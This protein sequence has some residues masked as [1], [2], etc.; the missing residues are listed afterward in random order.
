MITVIIW[1][2]FWKLGNNTEISIL[3]VEK[4]VEEMNSTFDRDLKSKQE[5]LSETQSMLR[6]LTKELAEVRR[7]NLALR[8]QAAQ[9]PDL[10]QKTKMLETALSEETARLQLIQSGLSGATTDS[11]NKGTETANI[12]EAKPTDSTDLQKEV[13]DLRS[14]VHTHEVE[15][16]KLRE[17]L[18][19]IRTKTST[20][21]ALYRKI[22]ALCTNTP[23][24]QIDDEYV[25]NVLTAAETDSEIDTT[26][27]ASFMTKMRHHENNKSG[28]VGSGGNNGSVSG[29]SSLRS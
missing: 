17:A 28:S 3:A 9:L 24:N 6:E 19:A 7:Q 26:A 25:S 13:T 21:D 10:A 27:I 12:S 20:E 16:Q 8:Q 23:Q 4:M 11:G 22:I 18:A 29:A 2:D 1:N 5:Q 14:I 15:E